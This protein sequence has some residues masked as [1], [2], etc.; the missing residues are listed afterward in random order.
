MKFVFRP[1]FVAVSTCSLDFF[2]ALLQ[3]VAAR[4]L[5]RAFFYPRPGWHYSVVAC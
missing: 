1:N 2:E 5:E 3:L 4:S